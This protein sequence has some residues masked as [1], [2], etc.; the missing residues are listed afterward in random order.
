M[1]PVS[2][3]LLSAVL[4][5]SSEQQGHAD[6]GCDLK[7]FNS[8]RTDITRVNLT[9]AQSGSGSWGENLIG[10]KVPPGSGVT[11][12]V[13]DAAYVY[14]YDINIEFSDGGHFR[15]FRINPCVD[16]AFKGGLNMTE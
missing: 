11:I 1:R 12:K 15:K 9:K 16:A 13:D 5:L 3:T 2:L 4:L 7:I 10:D 14:G 8:T 6:Q